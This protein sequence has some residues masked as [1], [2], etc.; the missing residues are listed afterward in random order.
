LKKIKRTETSYETFE[1]RF[2]IVTKY[3]EG[4]TTA[5]IVYVALK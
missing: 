2:V 5:D 1:Y 3:E 4:N